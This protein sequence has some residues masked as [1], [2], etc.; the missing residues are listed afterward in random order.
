MNTHQQ[1][2]GYDKE[3]EWVALMAMDEVSRDICRRGK[4]DEV[5]DSV[6]GGAWIQ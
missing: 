3:R 1:R 6:G 2:Y 4:E 5:E